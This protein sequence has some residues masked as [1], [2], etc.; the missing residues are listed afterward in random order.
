[1]SPSVSRRDPDIAELGVGCV[2]EIE[3]V[4]LCADDQR[5][6]ARI[7]DPAGWISLVDLEEGPEGGVRWAQQ[8]LVHSGTLG[9]G[10]MRI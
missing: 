10:L 3:E 8:L 7:K 1:V 2:V 6:R 4:L 9:P 5:L